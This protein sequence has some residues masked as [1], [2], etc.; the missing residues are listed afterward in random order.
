MKNFPSLSSW[1]C[2]TWVIITK[3][4]PKKYRITENLELYH[5]DKSYLGLD[6]CPDPLQEP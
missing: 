3:E 2:K 1:Q 5:S 6:W 4:I